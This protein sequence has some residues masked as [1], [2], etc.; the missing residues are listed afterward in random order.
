MA[1]E[2]KI[3]Y[4]AELQET[5]ASFERA[6]KE[7]DEAVKA[8]RDGVSHLA[9][10]TLTALKGTPFEEQAALLAA[11]LAKAGV[12]VE[13]IHNAPLKVTKTGGADIYQVVDII[14]EAA[15]V[16]AE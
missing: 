7:G 5:L 12:T 3:D 6:A 1:D 15:K 2:Q 11:Q 14:K 9:G 10:L 8:L 4:R 16:E 13:T